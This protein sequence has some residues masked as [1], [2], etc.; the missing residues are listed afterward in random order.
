MSRKRPATAKAGDGLVAQLTAH[1]DR[2]TVRL[3]ESGGPDKA[4]PAPEGFEGLTAELRSVATWAEPPAGL[5]DRILAQARAP[6]DPAPATAVTGPAP[7]TAVADPAPV[8]AV[9]DPAPAPAAESPA[10]EA[11]AADP[12]EPAGP[13]GPADPAEEAPAPARPGR[14]RRWWPA[15]WQARWRPADWRVRWGRLGWAVPAAAL[16]AAMFT[17]GVLAVDRAL[18]PD[19]S[20]GEIYQATGTELAPQ[21]TAE[22]SV[23][24][25]GS[26][27]SIWVEADGLPAA[28]AG[29]YYAA[30]L[31]G[32][33]GMVPLGT[34]HERRTGITATMWSGVDPADYDTLVVTLQAEGE[35]PTPSPL[36]VMIAPLDR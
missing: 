4:G 22:V 5:R 11:P 18:Q 1:L 17:G 31:R 23:V 14:S 7:V 26:G 28:A 21:A 30:W 2:H 35:P 32:E 25:T 19:R 27:F 36:V 15:D 3:A 34:F 33:Q 12:A 6:A 20:D 8:T 24:E 10:P 29:S 16:A 9:V 13:A